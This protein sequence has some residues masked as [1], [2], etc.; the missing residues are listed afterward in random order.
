VRGGARVGWLA[1]LSRGDL[2]SVLRLVLSLWARLADHAPHERRA[3]LAW[4]R[5]PTCRA[6]PG[7]WLTVPGHVPPNGSDRYG[8]V[9]VGA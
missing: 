9:H 8:H 7:S 4:A 2:F 5:Q 1:G 6:E 3:R